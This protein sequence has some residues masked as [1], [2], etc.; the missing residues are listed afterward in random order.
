MGAIILESLMSFFVSKIH[1]VSREI[2]TQ[3]SVVK[4]FFPGAKLRTA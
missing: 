1:S 2:G 3:I 4:A